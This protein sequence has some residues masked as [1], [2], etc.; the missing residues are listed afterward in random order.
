M[1]E[2]GRDS[3]RLNLGDVTFP[4]RRSYRKVIHT[5]VLPLASIRIKENRNPRP[6][7]R[8]ALRLRREEILVRIQGLA[9]EG[10]GFYDNLA[11]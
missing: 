9:P 1:T 5:L 4:G 7:V 6:R 10:G 8:F 3:G 11:R 2:G